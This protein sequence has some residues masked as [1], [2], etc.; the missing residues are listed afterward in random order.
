MGGE[1]GVGAALA[2]ES[3]PSEGRGFFSGL[4][5]EGY[6]AG[7]LVAAAAYGGLFHLLGWRGLFL[8]GAAPAILVFYIAFKVEESPAWSQSPS[9]AGRSERGSP[10]G[11]LDA[12]RRYGVTFLF[13]VILIAAFTAF[14]HG[15][16]GLYPT[17]PGERAW[18]PAVCGWC[19]RHCL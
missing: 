4:L 12:F 10:P 14:S 16:P 2:F 3:L 11:M 19:R 18:I 1:W 6:A 15:T 9:G 5:Q 7:Y 13:M 8:L 17:F